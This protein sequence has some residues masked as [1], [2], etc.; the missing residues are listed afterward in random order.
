MSLLATPVA[1]G[2][3]RELARYAGQTLSHEDRSVRAQGALTIGTLAE[4]EAF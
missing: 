4:S 3:D 2:S 1:I